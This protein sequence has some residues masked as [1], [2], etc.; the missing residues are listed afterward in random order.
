[1]VHTELLSCFLRE[2]QLVYFRGL[3]IK[4]KIVLAKKKKSLTIPNMMILSA[5]FLTETRWKNIFHLRG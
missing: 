4:K 2:T 3:I 5:E 1:M